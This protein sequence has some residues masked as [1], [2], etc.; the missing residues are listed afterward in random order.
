MMKKLLAVAMVVG[1]VYPAHVSAQAGLLQGERVRI[2]RTNGSSVV[3]HTGDAS[4]EEVRLVYAVRAGTQLEY[5]IPQS[6]I[7]SI[8][9]SVGRHRRFGR[10]FAIGFAPLAAVGGIVGAATY[11]PCEPIYFLDC[12][13]APDSRG[14][15]FALGLAVGAVI[16]LPV[17][18]LNGLLT[19]HDQ[20][21]PI[22]APAGGEATLTITSTPQRLLTLRASI[23]MGRHN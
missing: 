19:K 11:R 9:R 13:F 17:G 16:G 2:T 5:V 22:A 8:E 15:A 3:G 18:L 6:G 23:P 4:A 10:N 14:Q 21:A 12:M 1:A 20:W 7:R